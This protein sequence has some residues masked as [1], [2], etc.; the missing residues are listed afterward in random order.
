MSGDGGYGA[1]DRVMV[2]DPGLA[3]LRKIMREATG[4]EPHPNHHGTVRRV[5]HGLVYIDFDDGV[6]AP[7]PLDEVRHLPPNDGSA[8]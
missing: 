1:G 8:S 5:R 6:E 4:T 7:Y 3:M 2:T